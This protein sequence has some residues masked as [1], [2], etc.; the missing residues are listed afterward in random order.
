MRS[1]FFSIYIIH[2]WL[3][4]KKLEKMKE[5]RIRH[6]GMLLKHEEESK[7]TE[8]NKKKN[9][10]NTNKIRHAQLQKQNEPN[11]S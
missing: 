9:I 10:M 1:L 4:L 8:Q 6:D 2:K 5:N 3:H 11:S 7:N